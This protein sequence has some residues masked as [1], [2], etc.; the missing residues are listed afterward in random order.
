MELDFKSEIIQK[1]TAKIRTFLSELAY[2]TSGYKS[3]HNLT[4]QVEHQYSG[5]FLIELIQNAHDAMNELPEDGN[6][7]RLEILVAQDEQP[8]GALYVANDGLPFT[9]SNFES[10]SQLGQSDKDPQKSIGN[11]GIGFRSVLEIC[12]SPEIFSRSSVNSESFDGYCF[13]FDPDV[14][15]QFEEPILAL[16]R[17]NDKPCSPLDSTVPLIQWGA[18]QLLSYRE[19]YDNK[20]A[21]W[22]REE[23]TYLSPYLLPLPINTSSKTNIIKTFENLGF[24]SVIR[25]PFKSLSAQNLAVEMTEELDENTVLFLDRVKFFTLNSG[26]KMRLVERKVD[27]LNDLNKGQEIRMEVIEDGAGEYTKKKYWLWSV[28]IGG[29]ENPEE[30]KA[31][32]KAIADDDLPGR[33]FEVREARVSLA[34]R[35]NREPEQGR[36]NIYLPTQLPT[37]CAAHFNGPFYGDM[38]RTD[39]NIKKNY[40]KLLFK[41][42]GQLAVDIALG[43]L[44]GKDVDQA[45]AILDILAP[46]QVE[47]PAG[48]EWFEIIN[49]VCEQKDI[50]LVEQAIILNEKEWTSIRN[51]SLIPEIDTPNVL[52]Q[53]VMRENVTYGVIHKD[54][55]SRKGGINSL[56][57]IFS[58]DSRPQDQDIAK[59]VEKIAGELHI[60][61]ENTNWN[62]F[63]Y[64]IINL[65]KNSS[66][67]LKGRKILLGSDLDL[68]ASDE[69]CTIFF[70]PRQ[71]IDD[72]EI[73][74]EGNSSDIPHSLRPYIAFL[75]DKIEIYNPEDARQQTPIRK[76][77]E[78]NLV[79]RYRVQEIIRDVLIPRIPQLPV[80][81]KSTE[82]R[83]CKDIL[84]WGLKLVAGM[85]DRGKGR[86]GT[87]KLLQSLLVPCHG[88]W[89]PINQSSFGPSWPDTA[90][91]YVYEYLRGAD[92]KESKEALEKM[93]LPPNDQLW[94]SNGVLYKDLLEAAGVFD[95]LKLSVIEPGEWDARSTESKSSYNL[96]NSAPPCIPENIWNEY[97]EIKS[98]GIRKRMSYAG[99]FIYEVQSVLV[100]PGL[101]RFNE[102]DESTRI[103]LMN[104]IFNSIHKWDAS[105]LMVYV[106]KI[107]GMSQFIDIES[108]LVYCL[109]SLPWIAI[110]V[111][112]S[113][114]W[115]SPSQHWY[116]PKIHLAGNRW[117]YAHLR[118]LP[119][120]LADQ[121]DRN[122]V[123]YDNGLVNLGMPKFEPEPEEKSNDT[124]LLDDLAS[125]LT[126]DISNYNLFINHINLA[127]RNYEAYGDSLPDKIIVSKGPKQI[128]TVKPDTNNPIYLPD[129]SESFINEL[130]LFSLPVIVINTTDAKRLS[131]DFKEKYGDAVRLASEMKVWPIVNGQSWQ[132]EKGVLI[133]ES[134]LDWLSPVILTLYAFVGTPPPG[135]YAK[136]LTG[137][138][139]LLRNITITWVSPLK[140]GL[141]MG[142]EI[143]ADPP[144]EAMWISQDKVLVCDSDYKDYISKYSEALK[145]LLDRDDL[146]LPIKHVL[147]KLED[148]EL[149]VREDVYEA[150]ESLKIKPAQ[151]DQV[152][153]KWQG[154]IGSIIRMTIPVVALLK[155]DAEPGLVADIDNE[156]AL[157]DYLQQHGPEDLAPRKL[158]R[159]IRSCDG[160][161][162]LGVKLF[163]LFPEAA[164]LDKWNA[165]LKHLGEKHVVNNN[166]EDEY[167]N[168]LQSVQTLLQSLLVNIVR[169]QEADLI[170]KNLLE[171]L[172]NIP[173]PETLKTQYWE[174]EFSHVVPS[175]IQFFETL[176]ALPEEIEAL[177]KSSSSEELKTNLHVIGIDTAFS[178]QFVQKKNYENLKNNL[179]NFLKIAVAACIKA[180]L[181]PLAWEKTADEFT[182][183]FVEFINHHAYLRLYNDNYLFKL[184]KDMLPRETAYSDF[185]SVVDKSIN[186]ESVMIAL[187]ISDEDIS[188]SN[189][190]LERFKENKK[191]LNRMVSVGGK[192]FDYT[193][194]NLQKLW[195]HVIE[196]FKEDTLP[197]FDLKK[198]SDLNKIIKRPGKTDG[199]TGSGKGSKPRGRTSKE[200]EHL[201]G[202]TGEIHAFRILTKTYGKDIVHPGSWKSSYSQKVFPG[203][204]IND[205]F[206]CDFVIS[207]KK[208]TYYIEVKSSVD[209]IDSFEL[210]SSEI[211]KAMDLVRK[212]K[213]HIFLIM[214]IFNV[215]S[216]NPGVRLLPNPYDPKCQGIFSIEDAGAR[217]KYRLKS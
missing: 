140:A 41:R 45:K 163:E 83:L 141:W 144:V 36:I 175:I 32:T 210:G 214:H 97:K 3:L 157:I 152:F 47:V 27:Y 64:D 62:G 207:Q 183:Y 198:F 24:A 182:P 176:N 123:L 127:W 95:G 94:D 162:T 68:H 106:K 180:N 165:V 195:N 113:R 121:I 131:H 89:Y 120:L 158:L 99:Y 88:G 37:G 107:D 31:I 20:D 6:K 191:R 151:Y 43:S 204:I 12:D 200:M 211:R 206:G 150:L 39:I 177:E 74:V 29:D 75:S 159:L 190:E 139:Q 130:D 186:Y 103:A 66:E 128:E 173:F 115:A 138:I 153:D 46:S 23:M 13:F 50:D 14:T 11:K 81:L 181:N 129:S 185:W 147:E 87:L 15:R 86:S 196:Q 213:R 61:G 193:E 65:F 1:T 56:F 116:V 119:G 209:D 155:P 189:K 171:Q 71:G 132:S 137:F 42:I 40:N 104:S 160:F 57:K 53:E 122:P 78:L 134:E 93:L 136:K 203:N 51:T 67:P 112:G 33:W 215:L 199:K 52:T 154:D 149:P 101:D 18:E 85:P 76:F 17:G 49:K 82:S 25:L 69:N 217:I 4:E 118:P 28:N 8:Y 111:D 172:E 79:K 117:Q 77:L 166:A 216:E 54:L 142:D 110:D 192:E 205:S 55:M 84:I 212:S 170:F 201:I 105:W 30:S 9:Q 179:D 35:M 16:I 174:I 184:I 125:A 19:L 70:P 58:I 44:A 63:W 96:P 114:E 194:E 202:F 22:L 73:Q 72:D 109:K 60:N 59:T 133:G 156:E 197:N 26:N 108:P 178:P 143:I 98:V 100:I 146:E 135:L 126:E 102:F 21:G 92:T 148:I 7:G 5:R 91:T 48:K 161:Y 164:Q 169:R 2:E 208:K 90:G 124:R 145:N 10:L 187:S 80:A 34:V 188:Q 167:H 38:S 168:Q